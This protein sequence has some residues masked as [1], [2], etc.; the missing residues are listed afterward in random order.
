MCESAPP[1]GIHPEFTDSERHGFWSREN[2][3]SSPP[4]PFCVRIPETKTVKPVGTYDR[5]LSFNRKIFYSGACI[6]K[7]SVSNFVFYPLR[8]LGSSDYYI[9]WTR[10]S[11]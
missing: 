5:F 10:T 4:G 6:R 9:E 8:T 7:V 11:S 1:H 2:I 3:A